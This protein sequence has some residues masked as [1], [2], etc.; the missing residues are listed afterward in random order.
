MYDGMFLG[1]RQY[2]GPP[3]GWSGDP[4]SHKEISIT[5]IPQDWY[6][7][8]LVPMF[9]TFGKLYELRL[10]I[11]NITGLSR[12]FCF[13]RYCDPEENAAALTKIERL[14]NLILSYC[15]QCVIEL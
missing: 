1:M 11:D 3:P 5:G 15:K 9:S 10:L 7:D 14:V 4:P 6:E 8:Q 12:Q 13:V 2:G